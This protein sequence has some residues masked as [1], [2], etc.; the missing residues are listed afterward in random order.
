MASNEFAQEENL[1]EIYNEIGTLNYKQI[2]ERAL[3]NTSD[4]SERLT[5]REGLKVIDK[6]PEIGKIVLS[7]SLDIMSYF[8]LNNLEKD[9]AAFPKTF[10][11]YKGLKRVF[12]GEKM[13][14]YN[15]KCVYRRTNNFPF[16][17]LDYLNGKFNC[18][19]PVNYPVGLRKDKI[20]EG[21]E[22]SFQGIDKIGQVDF[23][24]AG[25]V[26]G[27]TVLNFIF[28]TANAF[29]KQGKTIASIL[30]IGIGLAVVCTG[31]MFTP[32]AAIGIPIIALGCASVVAGL[33]MGGWAIGDRIKMKRGNR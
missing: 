5:L 11:F 16:T 21:I 30:L 17:L 26:F 27:E 18:R 31:V 13:S 9:F 25:E 32:L 10:A 6:Q 2:L 14:Q 4:E 20:I 12:R 1:R 3:Q 8:F 7:N 19:P 23:F 24:K 22:K 15:Q 33:A 29:S 28:P